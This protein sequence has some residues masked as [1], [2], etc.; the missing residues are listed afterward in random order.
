MSRQ[1]IRPPAVHRRSGLKHLQAEPAGN[2]PNET[3]STGN[4]ETDKKARESVDKLNAAD[5]LIFQTEK[6]LKEYGD[7]IP[8]TVKGD[9]ETALGQLKE[10]HKSGDIAAIDAAMSNLNDKW[11][12]ASTEMYQSA[13][14]SQQQPGPQQE[15]GPG[16]EAGPKN[17][18]EVTDVDFEEVK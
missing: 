15:E 8:A 7:K 5:A 4:A 11:Q 14:S 9:L 1:K 10:A 6:Q 12:K 2:R 16:Q 3:G 17:D 13:Q 18:G